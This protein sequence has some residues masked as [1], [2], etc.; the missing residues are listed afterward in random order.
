[1]MV[2]ARQRLSLNGGL[3][4]RLNQMYI[5]SVLI[6]IVGDFGRQR[7][8]AIAWPCRASNPSAECSDLKSFSSPMDWYKFLRGLLLSDL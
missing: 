7:D 6:I 3:H 8:P 5:G 4:S 2:C 1:M